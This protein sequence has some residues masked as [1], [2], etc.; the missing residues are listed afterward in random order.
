MTRLSV[1]VVLLCLVNSV[2]GAASGTM[3]ARRSPST[4]GVP[5]GIAF[6]DR[7]HGLAWFSRVRCADRGGC[8]TLSVTSDGGRTWA[9]V[10]D[11]RSVTQVAVARG[12]KEAWLVEDDCD[13]WPRCRPRLLRSEDR[14]RSW[15]P[16]G[17][18]VLELTF[19]NERV[20]FGALYDKADRWSLQ[21]SDD[22]GRSWSMVRSPCGEVGPWGVPHSSFPAARRGWIA[23]GGQPGTGSQLKAVFQTS[24]GGRSWQLRMSAGWNGRSTRGAIS[25]AGYIHG[26]AAAGGRVW[27]WQ[28]RYVSYTSSDGGRTWRKIG[29]TQPDAVEI[30]DLAPVSRR[31]T[32]ALVRVAPKRYDIRRTEDGGRR[33]NVVRSW[34][35]R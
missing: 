29:F 25:S 11:P 18:G 30:A 5:Q 6:W 23:C 31:V 10:L 3:T 1:A 9:P 19:A 14:G 24:D 15:R 28:S 20:G 34:R 32:F 27:I 7:T 35:V 2:A 12:R 26:I 33:W 8:S 16:I 4:L 17:L 22:G 21:R 13:F